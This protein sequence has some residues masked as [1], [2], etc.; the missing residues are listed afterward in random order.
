MGRD[1]TAF[2]LHLHCRSPQLW[3]I[4]AGRSK[5]ALPGRHDGALYPVGEGAALIDL[6]HLVPAHTLV[7]DGFRNTVLLKLGNKLSL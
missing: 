3:G 5:A 2:V 4:S 6:R 7:P 1:V